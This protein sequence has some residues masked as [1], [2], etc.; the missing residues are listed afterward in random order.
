MTNEEQRNELQDWERQALLTEYQVCQQEASLCV[1]V[2][3]QSGVIFFVSA[4]ALAGVVISA[5]INSDYNLYRLLF[6]V[7]FGVFSIF[8]LVV[9]NKY[10]ARQ[11][12]IRRV[13]FYRMGMIERIL[14]LRKNLYVSFLDETLED[15]PLGADE[16]SQL[17][18]K[19]CNDSGR[20]PQGLKWTRFVL[21]ATIA[22]WGILIILELIQY[23]SK[24]QLF[25]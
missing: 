14:D 5:L 21:R 16:Q 8:L 4:L 15:N 12:F 25:N 7:G 1:Q 6:I 9:W 20:R 10:L 22:A 11:N 19:F 23:F 2:S 24:G 13:M 17:S 3:W 18:T